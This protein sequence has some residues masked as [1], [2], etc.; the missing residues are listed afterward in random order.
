MLWMP[1]IVLLTSS[2]TLPDMSSV[3]QPSASCARSRLA[4]AWSQE[5]H[6]HV[7]RSLS[8]V[9]LVCVCSPHS[10]LLLS[11]TSRARFAIS[12]WELHTQVW[13]ALYS[14]A[15]FVMLS[16]FALYR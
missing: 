9:N 10:W 13:G 2:V 3:V 16:F 11:I 15:Y 4:G 6:F 7:Q 5:G 1:I 12:L 14:V 8:L